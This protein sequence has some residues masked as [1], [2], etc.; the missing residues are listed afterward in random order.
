MYLYGVMLLGGVVNCLLLLA[1]NRLAGYPP[2]YG[3]CAAA[4]F[5]GGLYTGACMVAKLQFLGNPLC[6][7]LVLCGLG[8]L[9]FG[10][11]T[12]SLRRTALFLFLS[13]A[14]EGTATAL[15]RGGVPSFGAAVAVLGLCF[16][17]FPKVRQELVEV[18]LY[19]GDKHTTLLAL[20]DTGNRLTDPVTGQSVL[21]ADDRSA[22]TLL[23]LT[24]QQLRSPAETVASGV[25]PGLRLVPYR[26]VGQAA[27]LLVAIRLDK[28][29]IGKWEGSSLVA[30]APEGLGGKYQALTGGTV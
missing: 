22:Q 5:A 12:R 20:R 15:G 2:A 27:G 25:V 10:V 8:A 9:A 23:G 14:L 21:V 4:S 17:G 26:A 16:L 19:Q 29:R 1:A 13:M 3:R 11:D 24:R 7:F 18:E 30:F 28:V 6:R